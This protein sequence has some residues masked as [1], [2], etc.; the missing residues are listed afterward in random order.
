LPVTPEDYT[1]HPQ[2]LALLKRLPPDV[3]YDYFAFRFRAAGFTFVLRPTAQSL[4]AAATDAVPALRD[5]AR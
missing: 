4:S 2:T 5:G 3:L 1:R